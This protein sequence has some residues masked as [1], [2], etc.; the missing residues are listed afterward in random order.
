MSPLVSWSIC[1]S[2][3]TDMW[4]NWRVLKAEWGGEEWTPPGSGGSPGGQVTYLSMLTAANCSPMSSSTLRV[5][6]PASPRRYTQCTFWFRR[7]TPM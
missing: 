6:G 1:F 4:P 5:A 3:V 2:T 7:A